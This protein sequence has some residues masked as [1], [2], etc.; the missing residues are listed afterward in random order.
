M[1]AETQISLS[2]KTDVLFIEIIGEITYQC[3]LRR[4]LTADDAQTAK[5]ARSAPSTD[6][7]LIRDVQEFMN[8]K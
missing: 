8:L 3:F 5:T 7:S 1:H 4:D 2:D 6:V